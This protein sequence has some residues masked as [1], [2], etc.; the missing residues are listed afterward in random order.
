MI[1]LVAVWVRVPGR[2]AQTIPS[3][4]SR[5]KEKK[6]MNERYARDH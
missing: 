3:K 1:T 2:A 6:K 4:Q 5:E